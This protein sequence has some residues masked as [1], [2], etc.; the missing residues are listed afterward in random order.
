MILDKYKVV[1]FDL[2]GT[3]LD[4]SPGIFGS[5]RFAEKS[6]GL[7]PIPETQLR[8]FVGPPPTESY[9][10]NYG[11]SQKVAVEA[12]KFHR[13][14]GAEHGIYEAKVYDGIPE[15][16]EKLKSKGVKL[17]V[18]TLKRQDIAENILSNFCLK[19]YF[20]VIVGIDNQ[21]SL[22]KA[23]TIIIALNKLSYADRNSV[24]LIGDSIYDAE[25]AKKSNVDFIGV[26]YGFGLNT[27]SEVKCTLIKNV[28][29]LLT[30][31]NYRF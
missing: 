1:L 18:C 10:K 14:Y 12:T 28:Y 26:T 3:L 16:L 9:M 15:L 19:K 24:V 23:D 25:G 22:T 8:N 20:D 21:E 30:D 31:I 4:T 27:K 13:Q 17:G 6:L 7:N 29:E 11:V 2:D 5:V